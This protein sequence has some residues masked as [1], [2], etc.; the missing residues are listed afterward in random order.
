M[1]LELDI[2]DSVLSA[3]LDAIQALCRAHGVRSLHVFGSILRPD[4]DAESDID[5]LVVFDRSQRRSAFRQ[6][7]GFKEAMERLLDRPIDLVTANSIRNPFF[8][9]AVEE[10]KH[11]V[12]AA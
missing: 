7:F 11:L 4:F 3:R 10:S 5:F 9:R 12:Y 1:K 6:F 8:K 2:P